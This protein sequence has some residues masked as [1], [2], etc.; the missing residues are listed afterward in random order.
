MCCS[1]H[2]KL[3]APPAVIEM[4]ARYRHLQ[5]TQGQGWGEDQFPDA[6]TWARFSLLGPAFEEFAASGDWAA[7]VR[8]AVDGAAPHSGIVVVDLAAGTPDITAGEPLSGLTGKP[9]SVDVVVLGSAAGDTVEVD[10]AEIV[11]PSGGVG[12]RTVD[13]DPAVGSVRIVRGANRHDVECARVAVAGRLALSAPQ[14]SRWSVVDDQGSAWFPDGAPHKWD[15]DHQPYFHTDTATLDVPV[16]TWR[17]TAARGLEFER[18]SWTLEVAADATTTVAWEPIRRF[19]PAG[20]G[21]YSAD[22]HVHLNYSGDHV[23]DLDDAHRMQIGEGLN[24]IMLQSGNMT[25]SLVYDRELLESTAGQP[26]WT[27]DD[28]TALAGH[29]FRNGLLGHL[30]GM[31]LSAPPDPPFTGDEGTEHPY[32]WPPNEAACAQMKDL[33]ATVTY[34]HP[35]FTSLNDLEQLYSPM[36]TVEARELVADAAL[37]HVDTME[38]VSCFDDAGAVVLWHHLL[39]CGLRL[40]ATAGSD[41]FLSFAHGPTVASNPPGWGRMYAQLDGAPLTVDAYRHAIQSGRTVVTNGP[42]LTLEVGGALP[43]TVLDLDAGTRLRVRATTRGSGIDRLVLH[44]PEGE[45]ASTEGDTLDHELEVHAAGWVAAAAYGGRDEHT[46]GAPVFAHTT[47]VYL[48]VGGRRVAR[49]DS[50]RW[51]LRALDLLEELARSHGR[52]DP[53]R[54]EQQLG[55]LVAVIDAAR[56][57][58]RAVEAGHAII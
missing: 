22:L 54:H 9:I 32:D 43:G 15:V 23:L 48:D 2:T 39:N 56:H 46:L 30:H 11:V 57:R 5:R 1:E 51:C 27:A 3:D 47:P 55:D 13:V 25:G 34:A 45:I 18:T 41:V 52:F 4:I 36:R 49:P 16:G 37:G 44:G 14:V 6:F 7:A 8:A 12:L 40:T 21:W 35:S 17:V 33:G 28:H 50:A 58:Y 53:A 10:G 38:V 29:E 31:G 42:W 24:L 20:S 26:L 19:D